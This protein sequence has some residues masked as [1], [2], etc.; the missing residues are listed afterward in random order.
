LETTP[1]YSR[2]PCR[3]P[4][5]RFRLSHPTSIHYLL[6]S[7]VVD[8]DQR[9]IYQC[10]VFKIALVGD[11]PQRLQ[12]IDGDVDLIENALLPFWV[13]IIAG[14]GLIDGEIDPRPG[15]FEQSGQ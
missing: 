8:F 1:N 2:K 13:V 15:G 4:G 3:A 12:H 6:L 7:E 14:H 11:A 5:L 10:A 9:V